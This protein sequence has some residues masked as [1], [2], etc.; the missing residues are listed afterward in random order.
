MRC[1]VVLTLCA[2]LAVAQPRTLAPGLRVEEKLI[3]A[4]GKG[5]FK[6]WLLRYDPKAPSLNLLPVHAKDRATGNETIPEMAA[7]Y[8]ALAA[9]NGG[10][11]AFGTYAGNSKNNFVLD[12]RIF[13]TWRDRSALLLCAEGKD[14]AE[15]PAVA[16]THFTGWVYDKNESI[17]LDGVNREREASDLVL[18]TPDLGPTT[19]TRGGLEVVLDAKGKVLSSSASG[20][21][22]IPAGGSVLSAAGKPQLW[23]ERHSQPGTLLRIEAKVEQ[24]VCP[25]TDVIGAGPRIVHEGK[26]ENSEW[27]GF[28]HA[29]PRH[30]RTAA[31]ILA[32]GTL[33]LAVVDGRQKASVGM[34]LEELANTLIDLGARE[35]VNLDGGGSSTFYA[36]G[37]VWNNPSD[38]RP[39][40]VS[41][42]LLVFH[43]AD[44]N[45]LRAW[46][47][48]SAF[49]STAEK[50]PLLAELARPRPERRKLLAAIPVSAA[51]PNPA[52]ILREA[53]TMMPR[54]K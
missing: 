30:P 22:P 40:P 53:I 41:D 48:S 15:R 45:S 16:M 1:F 36:D 28:A 39:R 21:T 51:N 43:F 27:S 12:G 25:A 24:S 44:W 49:F 20:N 6:I 11:F 19:L 10:Y 35:A 8:G 29:K 14:H 4:E 2:G 54:G 23:L 38:G 50:A 47:Q 9:V 33:L 52:R 37:R 42:G 3:D 26:I 17:A 18:F 7:R 34:T 5:P 32:D 31:A 13:G 46:V